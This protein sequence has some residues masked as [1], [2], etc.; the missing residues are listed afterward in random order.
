LSKTRTIRLGDP[1]WV[2]YESQLQLFYLS[3]NAAVRPL[4]WLSFGL[5][6]RTLATTRGEFD[7]SGTAVLPLFEGRSEYE[8]ELEHQVDADLLSVRH[9]QFSL[10]LFPLE[11]FTVG[12][13]YR[14]EAQLDNQV[15]GTL[16]GEIDLARPGTTSEPFPVRYHLV[17][18]TVTAFIPRQ[19]TLGVGYEPEGW[20]F[21]VDLGWFDWSAYKSPVSI[22]STEVDVMPP[23]GLV[24]NLP[25]TEAFGI[26]DPGFEDSWA[27][28]LGVERTLRVTHALS[29]QVRVGYAFEPSPVPDQT[30]ATNFLDADRQIF[31]FGAGFEL[32]DPGSWLP[33]GVGLDLVYTAGFLGRR[34]YEKATSSGQGS[35]GFGGTFWSAG[36]ELGVAF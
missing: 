8:S 35:Y 2:F 14:E 16:E 20:A 3:V 22:T 23:E 4:D 30:A 31:G 11:G 34:R 19:A 13:S 24:F 26:V 17:T 15:K 27:L 25:A 28:R 29:T 9:A 6:V 12:L 1:Y 10:A 21:G 32:A 7:V 36:A 5:G 18:R 33:R